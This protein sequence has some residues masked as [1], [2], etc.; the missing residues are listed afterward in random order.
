MFLGDVLTETERVVLAKRLAI[1]VY[2]N[3]NKSY[4]NIRKDLKVSSATIANVQKML[5]NGGSGFDL[6]LRTIE[7][8]E[9][10]NEMQKKISGGFKRVF[11]K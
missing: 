5:E 10:A 6:A 4:E 11:G 2:L 3:K 1:A 7:A 8:E 9:W